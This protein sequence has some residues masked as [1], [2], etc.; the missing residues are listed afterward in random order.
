MLCQSSADP[1]TKRTN[2][3][4][5]SESMLA[6]LPPPRATLQSSERRMSALSKK[7]ENASARL[8][9]LKTRN[10]SDDPAN[11]INAYLAV[12]E[13]KSMLA[14]E[15]KKRAVLEKQLR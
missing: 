12:R 6:N 2:P 5:K 15:S 8:H 9:I 7:L 1:S 14:E 4:A 13:L 3:K 10:I 11:F